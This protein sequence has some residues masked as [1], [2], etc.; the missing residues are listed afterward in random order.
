LLFEYIINVRSHSD[1]SPKWFC[2]NDNAK[3][4]L[5]AL[6]VLGLFIHADAAPDAKQ[7]NAN[8]ITSQLGLSPTG[9]QTSTNFQKGDTNAMA[10]PPVAAS[11]DSYKLWLLEDIDKNRRELSETNLSANY[12]NFISSIR[13]NP[14]TAWTNALDPIGRALELGIQRDELEL[15]GSNLAPNLRVTYEMMLADSKLKL[16]DH[17]TNA[18]LWANLRTAIQNRDAHEI[19]EAKQALAGYLARRLGPLQGKT[20]PSNMSYDAIIAQ[21]KIAAGGSQID[22]RKVIMGILVLLTIMPVA[23]YV[24]TILLRRKK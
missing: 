12:S 6:T 7:P 9:P 3:A 17:Q 14:K 23:F 8:N 18:Q 15:A 2:I 21:Y 13:A 16:A 10:A 1:S 19:V 11:S 24:R 22:R 20:F 5:I 4:L